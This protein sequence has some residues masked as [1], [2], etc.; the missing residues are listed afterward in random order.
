MEK[1]YDVFIS[2]S[3]KDKLIVDAVCHKLESK[4]IRC[5]VASRDIPPGATWGDAISSAIKRSYVFVVV[6]SHH[7][8]QSKEVEKEVY[9]GGKYCEAIIPFRIEDS[10]LTGSLEYH[11]SNLHWLDALSEPREQQIEAL[12][13]K[14]LS[15]LPDRKINNDKENPLEI[16]LD[17]ESNAEKEIATSKEM[18]LEYQD[19]SEDNEEKERNSLLIAKNMRF[20]HKIDVFHLW[21]SLLYLVIWCV[22]KIIGTPQTALPTFSS[23]LF[24]FLLSIFIY[25]SK[26]L[27]YIEGLQFSS[28]F[29]YVLLSGAITYNL[30]VSITKDWPSILSKSYFVTVPISAIL[31]F[32]ICFLARENNMFITRFATGILLAFW[33]IVAYSYYQSKNVFTAFS[34]GV[35]EFISDYSWWILIPGIVFIL[36][37]KVPRLLIKQN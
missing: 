14:V 9:L 28:A 36:L 7:A 10:P 35:Q 33:A 23:F 17:S 21:L 2:H 8:N 37:N 15:L 1:K 6:F 32:F 19:S 30:T 13:I 31:V 29:T 5:W 24:L 27:D 20:L 18:P 3:A 4:S 26:K 22:S 11:L 25:F 12:S 16:D 34:Y